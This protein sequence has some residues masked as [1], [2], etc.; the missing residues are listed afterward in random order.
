MFL[1]FSR[2]FISK[3]HEN[4]HNVRV[5]GHL[6]INNNLYRTINAAFYGGS[7]LELK[8]MNTHG[9]TISMAVTS[10]SQTPQLGERARREPK[11]F[12]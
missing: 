6:N 2:L 8:K 11:I 1:L 7:N 4:K 10:T 12:P 9:N 5:Y 3:M